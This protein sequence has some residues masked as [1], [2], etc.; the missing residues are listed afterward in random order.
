RVDARAPARALRAQA[1]REGIDATARAL[2]LLGVERGGQGGLEAVRGG[3]EVPGLQI[4]P[5]QHV[6]SVAVVGRQGLRRRE[7]DPGVVVVL[8][9]EVEVTERGLELRAL[10]RWRL[11]ERGQP[12][13][14]E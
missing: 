3:L 14:Q 2:L 10:R 6:A 13:D 8:Q 5:R 4:G 7:A 9:L 11:L 1:R 12:G